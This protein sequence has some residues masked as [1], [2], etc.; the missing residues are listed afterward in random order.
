MFGNSAATAAFDPSVTPTTAC[1]ALWKPFA[2]ISASPDSKPV[3]AIAFDRSSL[4]L[5]NCCSKFFRRVL[6][7]KALMPCLVMVAIAAPTSSIG[8]FSWEANGS[9]SPSELAS[10]SKLSTP[11]STVRNRVSETS[12]A[13]LAGRR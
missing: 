8:T 10:S 7:S 4:G 5:M 2:L 11:R 9:A 13:S 12:P 6:A 1:S 3:M